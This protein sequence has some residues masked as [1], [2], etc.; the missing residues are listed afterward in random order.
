MLSLSLPLLASCAGEVAVS[1]VASDKFA[2][3]DSNFALSNAPRRVV[4]A[5][6]A[7][8]SGNLPFRRMTFDF[9]GHVEVGQTGNTPPAMHSKLTLIN[10]GGPFVE[11]LEQ[12]SSDGIPVREDYSLRYRGLLNVRE[13]ILNLNQ[14]VSSMIHE[15]KSLKSFAPLAASDAGGGSFDE[16]YETGNPIQ[17][18]NF[19]HL[20]IHCKYGATYPAATLHPKLSGDAQDLACEFDNQNGVPN[21][22]SVVVFL[23]QYG[24][25][26]IRRNQSSAF[27]TNTTIDNVRVE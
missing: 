5:I 3:L 2:Y 23:R 11:T 26:I 12:V 24:I 13:Q 22:H 21:T 10:A 4:T 9:T 18:V 25:A 19:Y 8:D 16:D 17:I 15:I 6:E 20:S 1:K 7:H 27:T 14:T